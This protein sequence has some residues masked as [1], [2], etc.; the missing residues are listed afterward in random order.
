MTL[1][2]EALSKADLNDYPCLSRGNDSF[3]WRIGDYVAKEYQHLPADEVARYTAFQ[4]RAAEALREHP[5]RTTIKLNGRDTVLSAEQVIPVAWLGTSANGKP[6]A[7]SPFVEATNLEKLIWKPDM[8]RAYADRELFDRRLREFADT[9][10][11]YFWD[12]YPTRG[13]DEIHYHV[14]MI[15][16]RL[17]QLLGTNGLYISKYNVKLQPTLDP[18]HINLIITDTALYIDRVEGMEEV[19]PQIASAG[20]V[21]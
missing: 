11:A 19:T 2:F 12:E 10:N 6:I 5:Y 9:L 17:D 21:G 8:Y 1:N 20:H 4:N 16:R 15:S 3:V 14:C 7:F 13:Q 18:G